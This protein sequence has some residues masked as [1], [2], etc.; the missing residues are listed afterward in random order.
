MQFKISATASC[1]NAGSNRCA[2][3]ILISVSEKN[4]KM[5]VRI[6]FQV[7]VPSNLWIRCVNL[8]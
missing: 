1:S 6:I 8:L 5:A 7:P 2:L 4:V 3:A